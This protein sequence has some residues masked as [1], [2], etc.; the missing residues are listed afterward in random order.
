MGIGLAEGTVGVG[1]GVGGA[2]DHHLLSVAMPL[3]D[4]LLHCYLCVCERSMDGCVV[5]VCEF[6]TIILSE[7][8]LVMYINIDFRE[9]LNKIIKSYSDI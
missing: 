4:I 9:F 5:A 7:C 6:G 8:D 3:C 1:G 2:E